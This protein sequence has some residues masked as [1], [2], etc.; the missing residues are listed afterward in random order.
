MLRAR[1]RRTR[2]SL[3]FELYALMQRNFWRLRNG[4]YRWRPTHIGNIDV[5]AQRVPTQNR[6]VSAPTR[7]HRIG[8]QNRRYI[9]VVVTARALIS[10]TPIAATLP[11]GPVKSRA[12]CWAEAVRAQQRLRGVV[13]WVV[14]RLGSGYC[15]SHSEL[16]FGIGRTNVSPGISRKRAPRSSIGW[17]VD[18]AFACSSLAQTLM[19]E[20]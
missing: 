6:S 17:N 9:A 5:G 8:A 2:R 18:I 14:V 1:N 7:C 10:R 12:T 13:L 16:K 15:H 20:S 3:M 4:G 11:V 19:F